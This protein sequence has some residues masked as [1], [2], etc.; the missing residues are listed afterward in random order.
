MTPTHP[1]PAIANRFQVAF[2]GDRPGVA[3]KRPVPTYRRGLVLSGWRDCIGRMQRRNG[4][5][6]C[7]RCGRGPD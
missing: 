5:V 7:P 1:V 4:R 3:C 6:I 2:A